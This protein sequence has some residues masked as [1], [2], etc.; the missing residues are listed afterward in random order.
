MENS[1]HIVEKIEHLF[2]FLNIRTLIWATVHPSAICPN[3]PHLRQSVGLRAS[4]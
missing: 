4:Q 3:N 1:L 2:G